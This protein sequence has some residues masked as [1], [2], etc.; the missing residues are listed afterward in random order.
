MQTFSLNALSEQF[1]VDRG[2]M[3]RALKNVSP[4]AEKTKGRPTFKTSTAAKALERHRRNV[5]TSNGGGSNGSRRLGEIADELERLCGEADAATKVVK[6]K[7]TLAAKQPH[8]RA[9]MVLINRIDALFK[10]SN[11]LLRERDPTSLAPYVTGPI[12]GSMFRE[13][14]AAIYG[15]DVEIDGE[16]MFPEYHREQHAAK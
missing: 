5:G 13:L 2:T 14:L 7:R 6:S 4:D 15:R 12:V 1:E 9:A 8:S 11:D 16:Q 3:V 10:E